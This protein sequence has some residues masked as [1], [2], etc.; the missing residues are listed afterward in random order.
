MAFAEGGRWAWPDGRKQRSRAEIAAG[1]PGAQRGRRR[2]AEPAGRAAHRRRPRTRF[3]VIFRPRPTVVRPGCGSEVRESLQFGLPADP[4]EERRSSGARGRAAFGRKGFSNQSNGEGL[5]G[6]FRVVFERW[7]PRFRTGHTRPFKNKVRQLGPK[8][9]MGPRAAGA[10]REAE[11]PPGWI[12]M[13]TP[14]YRRRLVTRSVVIVEDRRRVISD[15]PIR[16]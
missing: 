15:V 3:T 5:P 4:P 9:G 13:G 16:P 8:T 6:D 14:A 11:K 2:R 7:L 10:A 1:R 12:T